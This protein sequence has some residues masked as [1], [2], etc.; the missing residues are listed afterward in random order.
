MNKLLSSVISG[1]VKKSWLLPERVNERGKYQ[2]LGLVFISMVGHEH[3]YFILFNL[4]KNNLKLT[5]SK[6]ISGS[7]KVRTF[8]LASLN[9]LF[10]PW[11]QLRN[12]GISNERNPIW[13]RLI[14]TTFW[15]LYHSQLSFLTVTCSFL[16]GGCTWFMAYIMFV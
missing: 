13:S 12:V 7:D 11:L 16:N 9:T 6:K 5:F 8:Q 15:T 14:R 4:L 1:W 2:S 10:A 3:C